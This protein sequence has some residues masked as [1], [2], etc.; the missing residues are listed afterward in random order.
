MNSVELRPCECGCGHKK[1]HISKSLLIEKYKN[2]KKNQYEIA[3]EL[4]VTQYAISARMR[5]YNI[6]TQPKYKKMS[7][8]MKLK[9][10][11]VDINVF[12]R[13][14][15]DVA[16]FLGWVVS[17]GHI[18]QNSLTFHISKKDDEILKKFKAFLKYRGNIYYYNSKLKEKL[19][20]M[21]TL[22]INDTKLLVKLQSLG[23]FP[24]NKNTYPPIINVS[25]EDANR[26]FIRGLFE[27][28]GSIIILKN[29]SPIFEIV[30]TR[31]LMSSI[32][33][34]LIS[35]LGLKTTKLT[36]NRNL[37]N[38]VLLRYSGKKQVVKILDW[39]YYGSY[40]PTRLDRK[41]NTYI[42]LKEVAN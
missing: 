26:S 40:K 33:Q 8:L 24:K 15:R 16:W 37:R 12:S 7:E 2:E 5:D 21:A 38:H 13:I 6:V 19:Y 17:D 34:K 31:E 11:R 22:K 39:L 35:Y 9:A 27:G 29:G 14:G 30:G 20:K 42:N 23:I 28:D 18:S 4:G 1:W 41:Y 25:N 3:R 32:Q 36:V 10:K